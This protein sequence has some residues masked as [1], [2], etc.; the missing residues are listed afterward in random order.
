MP[1]QPVDPEWARLISTCHDI[2]PADGDFGENESMVS[3][4]E[5][6]HI[7][8]GCSLH[9]QHQLR[10]ED[11]VWECRIYLGGCQRVIARAAS[12]YFCA[13]LYDAALVYFSEFRSRKR[14]TH[15]NFSEQQAIDDNRSAEVLTFFGSLAQHL[16]LRTAEQRAESTGLKSIERQHNTRTATGRIEVRLAEIEAELVRVNSQLADIAAGLAKDRFSR[17][18]GV[19]PGVPDAQLLADIKNPLTPVAKTGSIT[20]A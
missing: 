18:V 5:S 14:T 19:A 10:P 6:G 13:R 20:A 7:W 12:L 17:T 8:H 2:L 9:R 4:R 3:E 11:N 16:Q 15:F 1:K